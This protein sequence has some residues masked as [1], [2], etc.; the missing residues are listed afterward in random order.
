MAE[1]LVDWSPN[2]RQKLGAPDTPTDN[3]G[4]YNL[5]KLLVST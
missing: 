5:D 3:A 1:Q 4:N 2:K